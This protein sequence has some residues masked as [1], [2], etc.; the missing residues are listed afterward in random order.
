MMDKPTLT[1]LKKSIKHWERMICGDHDPLEGIGSDDC[2][3]CQRFNDKDDKSLNCKGCPV[4]TD[5]DAIHCKKTPHPK[6]VKAVNEHG[7]KSPEFRRAALE[8]RDYLVSLL[9]AEA[10]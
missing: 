2:A 4:F 7:V 6:C 9:P 1:A 5:T 3:L 10:S 8:M